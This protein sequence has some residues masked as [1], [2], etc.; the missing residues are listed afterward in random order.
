LVS[1]RRN[2]K[3]WIGGLFGKEKNKVT[4]EEALTLVE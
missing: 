1:N 3:D 2:I 4:I